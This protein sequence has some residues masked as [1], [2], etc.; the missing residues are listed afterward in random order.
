MSL[1]SRIAIAV[2]RRTRK[3]A[4]SSPD[5]LNEWI[6]RARRIERHRPPASVT[7]RMAFGM[8][9]VGGFPVY[10]VAPP[11]GAGDRRIVYFHGG[12]Y[13]FE[14]TDYHWRLIAELALKLDARVTVPIY[15]LAPEHSLHDIFG[16]GLAVYRDVLADTPADHVAFVGDSAGGNMAVVMCMMA[17][18][19]GLPQPGRQVLISPGLD[20]TLENPATY[21]AEQLDPWLAI[22]GGLEAVRHYARDIDVADWRVSPIKGN[23]SVL[24]KTLILAGEYDLLTPGTVDFAARAEAAGVDL[25]LVLGQAMFHV[26]PLVD[27]LPE[28]RVARGQ[29]IDWLDGRQPEP[30][31]TAASIGL[32][33]AWRHVAAS[34]HGSGAAM[35]ASMS[36]M[37]KRFAASSDESSSQETGTATGAPFRARVE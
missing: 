16:M 23:L 11:S 8:R 2:L 35:R 29:I 30:A 4:F 9:A 22:Q 7:R 32:V 5:M 1:K 19:A 36:A 14:I 34:A 20:M 10:E 31:S 18:Q 26:W 6:R 17:A 28:A 33:S 15:P 37:W 12:A 27:T 24:P 13:C 3:N 25:E 21:A